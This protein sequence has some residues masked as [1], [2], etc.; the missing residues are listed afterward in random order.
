M[1]YL[2]ITAETAKIFPVGTKVEFNY[3]A[4][5]GTEQGEVT[6]YQ[7]DRFGTVL[8]AKTEAGE[9][10][11]ISGFTDIGIGVYLIK[12]AEP[13]INKNSPWYVE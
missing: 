9:N 7:T 13:R 8:T 3:G 12:R 11:T 1:A 5:Y 6:G 10:K 4:M 2:K